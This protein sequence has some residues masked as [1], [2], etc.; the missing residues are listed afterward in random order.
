MKTEQ[1]SN[2]K[3]MKYRH[4][5]TGRIYTLIDNAHMKDGDK[6]VECVIYENE[7]GSVFVREKNDFNNKFKNISDDK[8][9]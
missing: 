1:T 2:K 3:H 5:K 7:V 8:K 4:E 9:L 6:W